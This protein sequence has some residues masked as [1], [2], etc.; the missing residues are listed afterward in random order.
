M[1]S[2]F[3]ENLGAVASFIKETG[4]VST[5]F[6]AIVGGLTTVLVLSLNRI[7]PGAWAI[8]VISGTTGLGIAYDP[9]KSSIVQQQ[10]QRPVD[11]VAIATPESG[12]ATNVSIDSPSTPNGYSPVSESIPHLTAGS[13]S[14]GED[15]WL[16]PGEAARRYR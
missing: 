15:E 16:S 8:A 6:A 5:T 4:N 7:E 11:N 12:A 3:R 2:E 1:S 9:N 10:F 14:T 13:D